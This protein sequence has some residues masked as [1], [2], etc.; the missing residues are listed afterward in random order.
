MKIQGT[1]LGV[2][3]GQIV[4]A[5]LGWCETWAE[6]STVCVVFLWTSGTMFLYFNSQQFAPVGFL[7]AV[8]VIKGMMA[9][10]RGP[11]DKIHFQ[12]TDIINV[13]LGLA[14]MFIVDT[15]LARARGSDLCV[16]AY[17]KAW[18][19][20]GTVLQNL[21]DPDVKT[22]G[23]DVNDKLFDLIN[24]ADNL[25]KEAANEPRYWRCQ[26]RSAQYEMAI[27]TA[28]KIRN[29]LCAMEHLVADGFDD[30]APKNSSFQTICKLN[31]F[32]KVS[33]YLVLKLDIIKRVSRIFEH[34]V[35]GTPQELNDDALER[36]IVSEVNLAIAGFIKEV[37]GK[38]VASIT[39]E[40]TQREIAGTY[41]GLDD[42]D[43]AS[44]ASKDPNR[45][46]KRK[47]TARE[48]IWLENEFSCQV[49]VVIVSI[50]VMLDE[51]RELQHVLMKA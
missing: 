18:S 22:T 7:L 49:S 19:A 4:Q 45:L 3:M 13:V 41:V 6:I 10:C 30:G 12:S 35:K 46:L 42:D 48:R 24:L 25:G 32:A 40:D 43:E 51:L 1:V 37:S 50:R 20:M 9:D 47:S 33:D 39:K 36:D 29:C 44:K 2:I 38:K 23:K 8:F 5:M 14:L 28:H 27:S 15:I 34:E 16:V 31:S 21:F 11:G 26:W 17:K